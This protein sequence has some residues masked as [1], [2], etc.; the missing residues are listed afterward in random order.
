MIY[1]IGTLMVHKLNPYF[2]LK[3]KELTL[4]EY[5]NI[6]VFIY[7]DL[8]PHGVHPNHD[9]VKG[10]KNAYQRSRYIDI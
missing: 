9:R 1:I 3:T 6:L 2:F 5:K 10:S 4:K 8:I 7:I